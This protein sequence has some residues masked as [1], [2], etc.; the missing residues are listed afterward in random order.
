MRAPKKKKGAVAVKPPDTDDIVNIYKGKED[1][2]IYPSDQYPP[3]LMDL[4][5]PQ[6]KPDEFMMQMYRGERIPTAR[7][8]WTMSHSVRRMRI[9]DRNVLH[10]HAKPYASDDDEG[11]DLGGLA[12]SKR[13]PSKKR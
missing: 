10:K 2:T 8:Q 6:Y 4:L 7:E 9:K 1:V 13:G 11:E 5:K 12:G 3:W